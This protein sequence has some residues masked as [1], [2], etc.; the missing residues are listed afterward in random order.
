[1]KNSNA[2]VSGAG[3]APTF[4]QALRRGR[5]LCC[6]MCGEGRLFRGLLRME[7]ECSECRFQFERAP[8]Y[9]LGS[10]YIN[11]GLTAGTTTVSYVTL[12]FGLGVSNSVL[13]PALLLF[14]AVFPLVFFRYA[15]SL[16]LSLDCCFDRVGAEESLAASR[17]SSPVSEAVSET[18]S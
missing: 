6:P 7:R 18:N 15:R 14:C 9:F 11:Y 1:M 12:H 4:G 8:G 17:Q 5:G 10:T 16:W 3:L 13:M 2:H